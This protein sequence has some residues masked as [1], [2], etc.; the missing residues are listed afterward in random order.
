MPLTKK[1]EQILKEF[2]KS[3]GKNPGKEYFYA[4]IKKHP[5]KTK[6]WHL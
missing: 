6:E 1:G 5:R 3:Y 2:E 4:H